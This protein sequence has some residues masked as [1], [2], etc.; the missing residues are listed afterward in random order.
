VWGGG[1]ERWVRGGVGR[2]WLSGKGE[3]SVVG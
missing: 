1:Y 2:V 3:C